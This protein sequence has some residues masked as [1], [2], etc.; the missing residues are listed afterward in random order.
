MRTI[1]GISMQIVSTAVAYSSNNNAAVHVHDM[2]WSAIPGIDDNDLILFTGDVSATSASAHLRIYDL[3][4]SPMVI[5]CSVQNPSQNQGY[6]VATNYV[7]AG[8]AN[9]K[10]Y[11]SSE[12]GNLY[13]YNDEC[14]LQ[15]TIASADTGLSSDIRFVEYSGGRLFMQEEGANAKISQLLINSTGHVIT[16]GEPTVYFPLP[17][18]AQDVF[19]SNGFTAS[20][21][22]DNM[23]LFS[24][25]GNLWFPYTGTDK[26]I[27]VLQYGAVI[28]A[29]VEVC[30][31]TNLDGVTDLC[32]TDTN[33]DGV[34]DNGQLGALGAYRSNAN[35]TQ[36][37]TDVFCA[38]GINSQACTN[39]DI[40]TNGVGLTYLALLVIISYAFL[41]YIHH[42]AQTKLG[43]QHIALLSSLAINPILLLV[44]LVVDVGIAFYMGWVSNIIF[45]TLLVIMV[46]LAG[47]GIYR[48]VKGG[49]D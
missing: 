37:G 7:S 11:V 20:H 10:I 39:K 22:L 19:I 31:D 35:L 25:F 24:G 36:F 27:G 49:N 30:I 33:N 18:V 40:K 16:D 5:H 43:E 45:Y 15:Q 41:V 26:K 6:D 28:G 32:F 3:T 44:M 8:S 9:N 13:V 29:G 1:D 47:F 46:G 14:V 34:P 21:T 38:F 17:S 42:Q 2:Q 4:Q 23:I 48:Q 12:S